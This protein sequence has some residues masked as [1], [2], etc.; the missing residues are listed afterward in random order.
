MNEINQKIINAVI[1][2]AEKLCPDSLLLIGLYG[3]AATGD[4]H[5]KSDIDL[6]ILIGDEKGQ[7]LAEGFILQDIG[8]GYDI[9]CT[10]WEMLEWDASLPHAHLSKLLDAPLI[11]IKDESAKERLEALRE[12]ARADLRSDLR[13]EKSAAAFEKAKMM[14]A[15][16][17]LCDSFG[18]MRANA[19]AV[20]S[21]LLDAVM[22]FHGKYFKKGVKRTFEEIGEL[23]LSFPME[24]MIMAVILAK[25]EDELRSNLKLLIKAAA[26]HLFP[27]K[28]KKQ[29]AKENLWGTYE[30]MFSNWR[31]K[32]PEAAE[33]HDTYSSFMNMV[34]FQF[35]LREVAEDIA[36][37]IPEI[38]GD[39]DAEDLQKNS[40]VFDAAL[41]KYLS[42]YRKIG[43]EPMVYEDADAFI[44]HYTNEPK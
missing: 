4:L 1:K 41:E 13:F 9:Y 6:L 32:M 36:I 15:D 34:A 14:Y 39:F 30:E 25:T 22:L 27:K 42:E 10:T 2:R 26:V 28:E 44:A 11:Y 19:G 3:S 21:F 37:D 33:N 31:N 16:A 5:G 17:C 7:Q 40:E 24:D 43:M 20:I 8:I 35:M 12:K 38:M 18:E 23:H 29:P